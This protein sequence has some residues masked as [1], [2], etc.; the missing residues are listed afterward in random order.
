MLGVVVPPKIVAAVAA[1]IIATMLGFVFLGSGGDGDEVPTAPSGSSGASDRGAAS[2]GAAAPP[3][4]VAANSCEAA[5]DR[6][7]IVDLGSPGDVQ[8]AIPQSYTEGEPSLRGFPTPY[9]E[10]SELPAETTEIAVLVQRL[11]GQRGTDYAA[12]P[13]L[14]WNISPSGTVVWKVTGLD[15]DLQSLPATSAEMPLPAGAT[16]RKHENGRLTLGDEVYEQKLWITSGEP[17]LFTVFA[18]RDPPLAGTENDYSQQWL[19]QNA[20]AVGW[21]ITS[22]EQ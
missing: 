11:T 22:L 20:V 17:H 14:W 21:F 18:L 13:N 10:W 6:Q 12:D 2:G 5:H 3:T 1:A 8:P 19:I 16:E 7:L 9:L 4:T 15:P